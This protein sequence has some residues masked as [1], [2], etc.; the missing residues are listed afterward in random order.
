MSRRRLLL[1]L[2]SLATSLGP[3]GRASAADAQQPASPRRVG[4]LLV[5]LSPQSKE[6]Q[7]FRDGLRDAGY[8]EGRDVVIEWRSAS[9][10]YDKVAG[11]AADLV[12][13]KVDVMVVDG[14]VGAKGYIQVTIRCSLLEKGNMSTM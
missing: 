5:G 6:A 4:V 11:L 12:Q 7:A 3:F 14:T 13:S 9:G 8:A 2:V 10:E 1:A